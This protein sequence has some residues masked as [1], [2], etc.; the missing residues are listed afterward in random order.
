MSNIF[1]RQVVVPL[2]NKSGGGV[3][4]GDVVI[5]DTSNNAAFTTTTSASFTGG[6]G[7]V[8]ETIASN[9]TGRVLTAG[10]A[11]LV[12]VNASVT[13][14]HFG[15]THSVVK[16]AASAGASRT[17]GTF[18][19]FLTGG[20]TPTA[21]VYPV[22][23]LGTSLTNPMTTGGDV[24]YGGASGVPTRLANGS[25]GQ[26]LVSAGGTAAPA[27]GVATL[28]STQVFL[29]ADVNMPTANTF[30]DGPTYTPAAGTWLLIASATVDN[31]SGG[32]QRETG[33]LW[34]G[35]TAYAAAQVSNGASTNLALV[36]CQAVVA[37]SGSQTYKLSVAGN[38]GTQT[39]LKTPNTNNSGL[40]GLAT[41]LI[42]IRLA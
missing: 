7:I 32:G 30:Y 9:A 21:L 36:T 25:A 8:Q 33:K 1:G 38:G 15:A 35:T 37:A 18:C 11:A 20:T 28:T 31:Q 4:A 17:A 22:D 24:I 6:V 13:R 27:W 26:V 34:D 2:T 5:V 12:N 39:M 19:Q 40:T 16:Q 29:G 3:I 23:L 14:G 10:Y 42:A 41:Y